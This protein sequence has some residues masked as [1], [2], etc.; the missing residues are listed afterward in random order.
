MAKVSVPFLVG[1]PN[2][3]G[4]T[5]WYWQPSKTLKGAGFTSQQLGRDQAAAIRAAQQINDQVEAWR[6]GATLPQVRTLR[7]QGT[8]GA[9]IELYR[10]EIV[11]GRDHRGRARIAPSTAKTYESA[12]KRLE[13]WAGKHPLAYISRQR[14]ARLRD[15]MLASGVGEHAAHTTLKLG[16]QLFAFL[17]D[18][19]E[20]E[21]GKNP[22]ESFGMAQPN[23]RDVIWSPPARELIADTARSQG[24]ASIALAIVLGYAIGQREQD[25]LALTIPQYVALP[26]HKMQAEDYAT[27]SAAAPDGIPRGL[28][29]RQRKTGAWIEVPV[30]GAVR[31]E[32]EA[33]I[34]RARDA[35]RL[36]ILSDD[37]RGGAYAGAA[38][39]TRFQ[40]DFAEIR[41]QAATAAEQRQDHALAAEIRTLQFRDL[42]RTCVVYLGELGL[43]AHLIAAIT[44]HDIDETQRILKVY[45]PRTT[46]RAAR[47]IAL[48]SV[49]EARDTAKEQLA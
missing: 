37:T 33:A 28:R 16:R 29:V 43:D 40:R 17:I 23:A 13:A 38:G 32:L 4:S 46:G 21:Q 19:D 9:A 7:A 26:E 11:N 2:K 48:A 34:D 45:M 5:N 20:W 35:D 6:Q 8:L 41:E 15:G 42:R 47:A 18:R 36:T 3:D 22:F 1:K 39:Q 44:G 12:L 27:L 10:R 14:V 49:R 25:L 30:T 24:F 31:R